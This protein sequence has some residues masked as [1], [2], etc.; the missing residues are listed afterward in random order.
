MNW[1]FLLP[2]GAIN[3]IAWL[4]LIAYNRKVTKLN[5]VPLA[6]FAG[7]FTFTSCTMLVVGLFQ[8]K[9]PYDY[10]S[11]LMAIISAIMLSIPLIIEVTRK[12]IKFKKKYSP[13]NISERKLARVL[14]LHKSH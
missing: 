10:I 12:E 13:P 8:S 14:P 9:H 6:V 1:N 5:Y 11:S 7:L 3:T 2:I 4:L